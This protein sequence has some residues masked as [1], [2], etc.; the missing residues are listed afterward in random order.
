MKRIFTA[1]AAALALLASPVLAQ[2]LGAE[3]SSAP[4]ED[5]EGAIGTTALLALAFVAV[6]ATAV[7]VVDDEDEPTSP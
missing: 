6:A 7:V 5:S 1:S 4:V 3:R 2:S